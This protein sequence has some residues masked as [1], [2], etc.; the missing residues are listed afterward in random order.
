[1]GEVYE[2]RH[3]RLPGRFAIK[4]LVGA[5]GE[6]AAVEFLRFRREAEIA[7]SLRHPNIVQVVD[8]NQ[9]EDG[10][11]YIVME[12]LAGAD[13]AA[14]LKQ[15]GRF[16]P[17]RTASIVEQIADAVAAA[18][19]NGIVHRDLKPQNVLVT[20]VPGKGREL[21]KVVDFGISK[22]KTSATLTDG[23]RLLGTPQYMSPE[24]ARGE[25]DEIDGSTDQFALAAIAYELLCGRPAFSGENVPATLFRVSNEH[26]V[27]IGDLPG[28]NVAA[29][30]QV[31]GRA[32]AKD[33]GAR[34]PS[35]LAFSDAFCGA[36]TGQKVSR[37]AAKTARYGHGQV[38]GTRPARRA[39]WL[40]MGTVALV[41][42]LGAAA[43]RRLGSPD[44][45][46]QATTPARAT[47]A[48]PPPMPV[49]QPA[50]PAA[51]P[52]AEVPAAS[53]APP[54]AVEEPP[55]PAVRPAR[56]PGRRHEQSHDAG[57][58]EPPKRAAE[59]PTPFIEDL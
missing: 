37:T 50:A 49:Q 8:F 44:A 17:Q 26:P 31:L 51:P 38:R 19:S 14:E 24:Q 28:V 27:P 48:S 20:S 25:P 4:V 55:R 43:I 46:P 36:V 16:Q 11:P 21:V 18:H 58:G 9:M 5:H 30:E 33:K 15:A 13:L 39:R 12:F 23:S 41:G 40:I 47:I 29:I 57:S 34:Y 52:P 3:A 22:V 53:T 2:A 10:T 7:S 45:S 35:I 54:A 32:L 6:S 59:K 56:K 42:T 1:M